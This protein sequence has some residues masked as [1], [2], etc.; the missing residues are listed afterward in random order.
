MLIAFTLN[1]TIKKENLAF[2]KAFLFK[3]MVLLCSG[4]FQRKVSPVTNR[5]VNIIS[6]LIAFP[7][8]ITFKKENLAY[9]QAFIF[10]KKVLLS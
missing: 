9:R 1:I 10:L 2:C 7:L 8:N 5:F 4:R 3:K 6:K